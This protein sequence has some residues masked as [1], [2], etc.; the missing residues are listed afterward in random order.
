M[1]IRQELVYK[2]AVE[3]GLDA[4][5]DDAYDD[6]QEEIQRLEAQLN[7]FRRKVMSK[8][9]RRQEI[10]DKAVITEDEIKVYFGENLRKIQTEFHVG[11]ILYKGDEEAIKG[12]LNDIE[13]GMSFE[14]VAEK[15]FSNLPKKLNMHPWDLGYLRWNQIPEAWQDVIYG[16]EKGETSGII[17][18]P[19]E[20]F[21]IIKLVDR[22]EDPNP[23]FEESKPII[24][25]ILKKKKIEEL[26][27]QWQKKLRREAEIIYYERAG[28]EKG[29]AR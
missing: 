5:S 6:Y 9:F 11:Q 28:K 1:V 13:K 7:A 14:G 22:R 15:R 20:R 26:G 2:K 29:T 23:D 21:W 10:V 3:L 8:R 27:N 17:K 16:M 24:E 18:G 19:K 25:A 12:D 4:Y